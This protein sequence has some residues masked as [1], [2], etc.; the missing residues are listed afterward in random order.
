MTRTMLALLAASF[1][2]LAWTPSAHAR[3]L[4]IDVGEPFPELRL[5]RI[6]GE[7]SVSVQSL[8]GSKVLLIQFAS[9]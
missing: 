8:R 3:D 9:W 1:L 2:M 5:P 6:D 7:G 4:D